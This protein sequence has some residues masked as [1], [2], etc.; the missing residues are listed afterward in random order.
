ML[1]EDLFIWKKIKNT[2]ERLK[3]GIIERFMQKK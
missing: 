2:I 1:K 3:F